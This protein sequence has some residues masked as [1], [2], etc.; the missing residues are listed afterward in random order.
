MR[1]SKK[2]QNSSVIDVFFLWL[3]KHLFWF[4]VICPPTLDSY[5]IEN[6]IETSKMK[7]FRTHFILMH[8]YVAK[9]EYLHNNYILQHVI[10]LKI[11]INFGKNIL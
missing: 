2:K 3:R 10:S 5:E 4:R 11:A 1:P 6:N 7:S 9:F 8:V